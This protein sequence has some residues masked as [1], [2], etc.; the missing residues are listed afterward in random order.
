VGKGEAGCFHQRQAGRQMCAWQA[1]RRR[2]NDVVDLA[3]RCEDG[4]QYG[5]L[6]VDS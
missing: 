5:Q 6:G 2:R 4:Y 1:R 3:S